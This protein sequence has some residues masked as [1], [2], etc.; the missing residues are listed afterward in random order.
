MQYPQESSHKNSTYNYDPREQHV[1]RNTHVQHSQHYNPRFS[2]D[3][4]NISGSSADERFHKVPQSNKYQGKTGGYEENK[5]EQNHRNY[6]QSNRERYFTN[7]EIPTSETK[8]LLTITV[9]IGNG[10][11]ENI[12]I[13]QDDTAEE[14][15]DRFCNKYDMN[16]ELRSVFTEQIAQNIEQAKQEMGLEDNMYSEDLHHEQVSTAIDN[17][18]PARTYKAPK[19]SNYQNENIPSSNFR[20]IDYSQPDMFNS[21]KNTLNYSEHRNSNALETK[22]QKHT[23]ATPG[24]LLINPIKNE[25]CT[26]PRQKKMSA[27]SKGVQSCASFNENL[28]NSHKPHLNSHSVL[29]ANKK[30]IP[31]DSVYRRLHSEALNK[32]KL[33]K[34]QK[35]KMQESSYEAGSLLN[36]SFNGRTKNSQQRGRNLL[37]SSH[38][39][40]T[41]TPNN[42][43]EKLYQNGLKRLE[44]KKRK[45]QKEKLE[46]ELKECENLTF[47]P[48]INP[49]S[50][51]FGR[52]KDKP[53][54]DHLIEKGKKS[55]DMIEKKRSEVLL[56]EM[57]SKYSFHPRI[58]KNSERMIMERSR[59]YIEENMGVGTQ[60]NESSNLGNSYMSANSKLDK[61]MLL[62]DDALKRKQR[63]E[64]I[65]AKC[66]DSECTFQPDVMRGQFWDSQ[67]DSQGFAERLSKVPKGRDRSRI[68]YLHEEKYDKNTGQPLFHPKVGRPPLAR[69]DNEHLP[70]TEKLYQD[71]IKRKEQKEA[72]KTHKEFERERSVN[73]K[74][75][76]NKSE[77]LLD[78]K[79]ARKFHEIFMMLDSDG[80]GIISAE[81]IDISQL[82]PDIL[83]IFTPLF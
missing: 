77:E 39:A 64:E 5:L 3:G 32:Q 10:E 26:L 76:Q 34:R 72:E 4:E 13:L 59:Q 7:Q 82:S 9:E 52:M 51:Y 21:Y 74:V 62:Y 83:E 22:E 67:M 12:V 1:Y 53:L 56:Y 80:D 49:I 50:R 20:S 81:R 8:E 18:P 58:N 28:G 73:R 79:K 54:E 65:Y 46:Q 69:R 42:Y 78:Q 66:L 19:L 17:T 36:A 48:Q 2:S 24:P 38:T 61:F 27:K 57:Q 47:R 60:S 71:S 37:T 55:K 33:E 41:R 75:V 16:D 14:V 29:L 70:V 15:A 43:G 11:Q 44:E 6:A 31:N 68:K 35:E 63:K 23:Y 45:N 30:R 25:K 40:R